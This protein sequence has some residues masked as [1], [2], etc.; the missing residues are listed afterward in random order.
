VKEAIQRLE[1]QGRI[2]EIPDSQKRLEAIARDYLRQPEGT[3]VIPPDNRSRIQINE[4]VHESLKAQGALSQQEYT[5]TAL[6]NR[7]DLT[8]TDRQWAAQYQPGMRSDTRG[9]AGGSVSRAAGTLPSSPS[10]GPRT[11]SPC[12]A[13]TARNSPTIL[14]DCRE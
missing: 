7:Q 8:G 11:Y 4:L 1:R 13:R 14:D 10:I 2:H 3:F 9:A 12:G 5:V 6:V